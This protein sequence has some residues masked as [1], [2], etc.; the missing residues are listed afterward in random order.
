MIVGLFRAKA[1]AEGYNFHFGRAR[2]G[3]TNRLRDLCAAAGIDFEEVPALLVDGD[4][5]SSSRV[6]AALNAG[7][8]AAAATLLGR[9]YRIN[10]T[11]V[12]GAKRGRT[13]GFPTANVDAV[14]TLVPAVGVYAVR[15]GV[16]GRT[17]AA[18][19]NVGPNPTF[20]E[21]ARKIEIHLLDFD[22]DVYGEPM[23]VDFI[24]RVRDTRPFAGP[25][26]LVEQLRRDVA[27]VRA[28]LAGP[29]R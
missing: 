11:I 1:V 24:A 22:G 15:A 2:A 29:S 9:P 5:V 18:A 16:G 19:A 20:G 17:Y 27:T 8:V 7:D 25:D 14:P 4:P 28:A 21:F 13:I 23:A 3:D 26:E 6:R 12:T 10:G